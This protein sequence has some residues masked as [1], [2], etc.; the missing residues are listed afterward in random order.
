MTIFTIGFTQKSA[1][2][3]FGVL[4]DAGIKMIIDIRLNN[5]SQLAG[6]AKQNDLQFFL[7]EIL[8]ADYV[9]EP[10][11][12][13]TKDILDKYRHKEISWEDYK[14]QFCQLL[15]S[16]HIHEILDPKQ[17]RV[18]TALLCSEPSA[19]KCHR[20]LVAQYLKK[21]WKK[22]EIIDL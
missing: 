6:F 13:P 15:E 3:F 2:A 20:R 16:R 9:H 11:L 8:G 7:K 18:P 4:K 17:F 10:I 21:H 22:I 14:R 1:Q 5:Q 19:D 12:A